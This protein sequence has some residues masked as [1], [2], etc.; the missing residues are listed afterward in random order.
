M[1]RLRFCCSRLRSSGIGLSLVALYASVAFAAEAPRRVVKPAPGPHELT[2]WADDDDDDGDGQPDKIGRNPAPAALSDVIELE[3]VGRPK[4]L[5]LEGSALRIYDGARAAEPAKLTGKRPLRLG[6]QGARAG[7]ATLAFEGTEMRVRVLEL[8]VLDSRDNVV[9]LARSHASLSRSIPA[10]APGEAPS[11]ESLRFVVAGV[12]GSLPST[13]SIATHRVSLAPL[14]S[15]GDVSLERT[16]CPA[17]VDAELECATSPPITLW[18]DVVDR[19]HPD[20]RA[21]ALVAEVGGKLVVGV[22]DSLLALRIGGPR[23]G[24][25]GAVGR[26]RGRLRVRILRQGPGGDPAIGE[27]VDAALALARQEL[28]TANALFGQCG[29]VFG[30]ER[31]LD[32]KVVDPPPP[33]L[34]ALGCGEG[35]PASG[36]ALS[37]RVGG[38]DVRVVTREGDTPVVVANELARAIGKAGRVAVVSPNAL[39]SPGALR[40]VDVLVR[41]ERGGPVEIVPGEP[42]N[43]DPTLGVCLGEVELADG[44]SYF[45]DFDAAAGTLEERTLLKAFDDG[46]P[47]SIE[48]LVVPAFA[49]AGRIGESFIYGEGASLRNAVIVDRAAIRAGPRSFALSHELGHILLNLPGHPDDFG[50]DRPSSLMDA[51][52]TDPTVFGPRRLSLEECQRAL[53]ESGPGAAAP[54]LEPWPL[55]RKAQ[56]TRARSE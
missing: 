50:V 19:S 46:D 31:E 21:T 41:D 51:D 28:G 42:F 55:F 11:S 33:H 15:L 5:G 29:I 22:D 1:A 24:A 47:A 27:N 36:G 48:V 17:R 26:L 54:L 13:L 18:G 53:R 35:L 8:R 34:V 37:L 43:T 23:D 30:T 52:A 38:R 39:A 45:S 40:S 32:V 2:L 3:P 12:K 10:R 20:V 7:V 56:V 49:R 14:D 44:L 4:F 6:V 9:D 16:P 25:L